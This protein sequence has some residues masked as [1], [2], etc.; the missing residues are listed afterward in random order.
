MRKISAAFA[1]LLLTS[2][3]GS[4]REAAIENESCVPA[5]YRVTT[6]NWIPHSGT[7]TDTGVAFRG[8]WN[9]QSKDCVL[10]REIFTGGFSRGVAPEARLGSMP[11]DAPYRLMA[12]EMEG[13]LVADAG[14][15]MVAIPSTGA[16]DRWLVWKA[17]DGKLSSDA[18]LLA[19]CED[20][21]VLLQ[22][23]YEST[24]MCK[25]MVSGEGYYADYTFVSQGRF[26]RGLDQL[27][28]KLMGV[29]KSWGCLANRP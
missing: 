17:P 20:R 19:A 2:C 14:G 13:D 10:P 23:K 15:Q 9:V 24:T 7:L 5:L 6:P 4:E 1:F 26:P 18:E 12:I 8:C 29:L 28:Q 21:Q 27:D 16:W 3:S 11:A 22:G 25:R